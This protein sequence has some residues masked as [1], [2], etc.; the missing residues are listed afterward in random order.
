MLAILARASAGSAQGND[1]EGNLARGLAALESKHF[2]EAA[3][4][5]ERARASGAPPLVLF[6]LGVAYASL[7]W[8]HEAVARFEAFLLGADAIA[9]APRVEAARREVARLRSENA[10]LVLGLSP[11]HARVLVDGRPTER[12]KGE[13]LLS[14][15]KRELSMRAEGHVR[16]VQRID[17]RPGR[18]LLDVVLAPDPQAARAL[19]PALVP[20]PPPTPAPATPAPAPAPEAPP[21]A[22]TGARTVAAPPL[23]RSEQPRAPGEREAPAEG[24]C[25]GGDWCLGPAVTLGVLGLVGPG[26]HV[27]YA[28]HVAFFIDFQITP[29]ITIG[30]GALGLHALSGGARVY[31]FARVGMFLSAGVAF[32]DA[33]GSATVTNPMTGELVEGEGSVSFPGLA[34]GL[35]YMGHDGLVV[36]VDFA[37]VFPIGRS[38]IDFRIVRGDPHST[39]AIT[40]EENVRSAT[41]DVLDALPF[42]PQLNLLRVGYLF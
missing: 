15:G 23:S 16:Q 22:P 1:A 11:N 13:I 7:R 24:R 6:H 28:E 4:A 10:V 9:D 34:L 36:G 32:Y 33:T 21:S 35:G 25:A 2:E 29:S 27:R 17:A 8:P 26:F 12:L 39:L 30:N 20:M 19:A 38:T 31:P 3:M 42:V 14:P 37:A 41:D 5:L 40:A 18:F